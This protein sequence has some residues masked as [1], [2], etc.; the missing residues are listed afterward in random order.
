MAVM[1]LEKMQT[2]LSNQEML[3]TDWL[4]LVLLI[5]LFVTMRRR[6]GYA[7]IHDL[8]S[9]TR[10][11]VRPRSQSRP[12]FLKAGT[13]SP[14]PAREMAGVPSGALLFGPYIAK[15]TI[16]NRDGEH[17]MNGFDPILRRNVWIHSADAAQ[18]AASAE[19]RE[20]SRPGRL[21]WLAGGVKENGRWNAYEAIDGTP[22]LSAAPQP[23]SIVRYWLL[24]LAGEFAAG[25]QEPRTAAPVAMNR[26]WVSRQNRVLLLDFP[27]PTLSATEQAVVEID[28]AD[29]LQAFLL[30]V[31][32]RALLEKD[33]P[34]ENDSP[35]DFDIPAVPS[36]A[37]GFL[38][39]LSRRAFEKA[40]FIQG[41]L[42]SLVTKPAEV[43]R[44]RRAASLALFPALILFSG[45]LLGLMVSFD[46]IRTERAW[47]NQFPNTPSFPAAAQLYITYQERLQDGENAKEDV[48]LARTY[49]A[50]HFSFLG[51]NQNFWTQG[52]SFSAAQR[53]LLRAAITSP[54]ANAEEI[55]AAEKVIPN[56]LQ[57]NL[58]ERRSVFFCVMFGWCAV[59]TFLFALVDLFGCSFTKGTPVLSLFSMMV[60]GYSGEP[61]SRLRLLGRWS[62]VWLPSA[63]IAVFGLGAVVLALVNYGS[64]G[65][66]AG[67]PNWAASFLRTSATAVS[68]SALVIWIVS[69]IYAVLFPQRSL[70]DRLAG[71][72]LVMK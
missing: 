13:G 36:H 7:A 32:A 47:A 38:K 33:I 50:N 17:L 21:R 48:E 2:A 20:V 70:A 5:L 24:D 69:L 64:L 53:D 23:W 19:Q 42:N 66:S 63:V 35:G 56:R 30:R 39:A 62:L 8:V 52:N 61:A 72:W 14:A 3:V 27:C 10:V 22:F 18:P 28:N 40:E 46:T 34:L 45:M 55:K 6:N 43:T 65:D 11:I 16:W 58:G 4:W 44:G 41:N 49:L 26:L 15:E 54:L 37:R 67:I 68:V 1:P 57:G 31:S 12:A 60:V 29:K 59:C 9:R 25:I 71:T 51:T